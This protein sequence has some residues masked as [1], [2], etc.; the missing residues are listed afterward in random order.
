MLPKSLDHWSLDTAVDLLRTR[1]FE[2]EHFDY[3]ESLPHPNDQSAKDRLRKTCCGLANTD[4]GFIVFGI[5]DDR[6]L[7]PENRLLG[8]APVIDFPEQFGNYPKGCYPSIYWRFKNPPIVLPSG[9]LLHVVEIPASPDSPHA[10][11]HL[12]TGWL[13]IKRSNKGNEP[14]APDEVRLRFLSFYEKRIKLE[15]LK[16]EL[17]HLKDGAQAG[18]IA[19]DAASRDSLSMVTY[20]T[21]LIDTVLSD[22]FVLVARA[23]ALVKALAEIRVFVRMAQN[24]FDS[25]SHILH[26][27]YT[28]K[29]EIFRNHNRY[30]RGLYVRMEKLCDDALKELNALLAPTA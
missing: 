10:T 4:G 19:D 24:A 14:M 30:V 3:K 25:V 22:T 11:G 20:D 6:A 29:E 12:E 26:V 23:P 1:A 17:E 27:G 21:H 8:I 28:N 2:S 9:H 16:A 7:A 13:F 15:L 5:S 18:Y